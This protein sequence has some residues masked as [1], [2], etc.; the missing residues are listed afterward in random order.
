MDYGPF[1]TC[2]VSQPSASIAGPSGKKV[3]SPRVGIADKGIC[4]DLGG[5]AAV[6]FDTDTLRLA[7][8]WTGGFL[9]L[10]RTNIA[11]QKGN[12]DAMPAGPITFTSPDGPGW[13][14]D[15]RFNDPRP[16]GLGPLPREWAHYQGL[17]RHGKQV[18]LAYSVGGANILESLAAVVAGKQV[19]FSR[20]FHVQRS[21]SPLSMVVC[22]A[23]GAPARI[24]D[25]KAIRLSGQQS[26]D[27][28]AAEFTNSQGTLTLYGLKLP[29]GAK[30]R[31]VEGK[32]VVLDLPA[33][34]AGAAFEVFI[35][36]R[37]KGETAPFAPPDG[38][39]GNTVEDLPALCRGGPSLW[40]GPIITEG[41]RAPDGK[42][43][44][45]VD[46][47]GLPDAN[48]WHSW[49]RPS[50]FD[51]FPD[52]RCAVATFSGDVW[53][54]SGLDDK[55]DHVA[56][57]R[58]AT[59]LYEPLGLKVVDGQIYVLGRDQIT[60]LS[61]LDGDGEADF[62]EDFNNDLVASPAYHAFV[63]DLQ[64]DSKGNFWYVV[65][66]NGVPKS[67][68]MHGCVV[69]VSKYGETSQIIATGLRAANGTGMG[70]NDEF[71]C[72]DNQGHWT[73]VCR[74]NL[75]KPGGQYGFE[76][77]PRLMT[78]AE[79]EQQPKTYDPPL[80]WIPYEQDNS[81]GGQV[82]VTSDRWGPLKGAMLSTSYGKCKLF[83]VLWER[84]GDFVQGATVPLPL[85][86]DSGIM[87]A[88][89]SPAD[90]QLYVCGLKGWQTNSSRDGCLQRVRYTGNP[91]CLPDG[92][93]VEKDGIRLSF[94]SPL[95]PKTANDEQSFGV[96]Q[97]NY[98]WSAKYGSSKY[99]VSNPA[100]VGA[101]EVEV[102]SA[103]L[104]ED[105]KSVFL[106][107][108]H[109]RP[110]M[111]MAIKINLDSAAG[112]PVECEVDATINHVP[113]SSEPPVLSVP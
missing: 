20:T 23:G 14:R 75:V 106:E 40:N 88:R 39:G 72:S 18:V 105:H 16:G 112:A 19:R 62:Y 109:L 91:V 10:H 57:K 70:P 108:P 98:K 28:P 93:H 107:I 32:G 37:P 68:P 59:G 95:D 11:G 50:A 78:K 27:S 22:D 8:G 34:P 1:L 25:H 35:E 71:V 66:G 30:F 3:A 69:K 100:Q 61:D 46:T 12:G 79:I 65:D 41:R 53:I 101:D 67:L 33:M 99:K 84:S 64:T 47:V 104:M 29:A 55:L 45:V 60:R 52:G 74:I 21:A 6:C 81:T 86:F 89:F 94:T 36:Y 31:S 96:E 51:F 54:V 24:S 4:I 7:A 76:G 26:V 56:W 49:I 102:K 82:F 90:G 15:G 2:S 85:K 48:P 63:F 38:A 113:G 5:G 103:R 17:Y 58:F 92:I 44:Y 43:P 42:Q 110:V 83:E 13:A 77:D 97:Y 87:R 80:C 73:P 111:Q 9:D